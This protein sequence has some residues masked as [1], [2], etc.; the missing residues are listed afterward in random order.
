MLQKNW[1]LLFF[2]NYLDG[3]SKLELLNEKYTNTIWK[4][5]LTE[6]YRKD[7]VSL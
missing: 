2:T 6:T 1:A 4:N 5:L 3:E 7:W